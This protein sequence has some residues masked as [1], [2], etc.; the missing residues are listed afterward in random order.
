[1]NYYSTNNRSQKTSFKEA[2]INGLAPDGGLYMPESIPLLPEDFFKGLHKF[3]LHKIAFEAMRAYIHTEVDDDALE[4]IIHETFDFDIPLIRIEENFFSLELFHGPTLSFKDVGARFMARILS[5]LVRKEKKEICVL[6][7]TSGDTGSAVANGF[8]G[9]EGIKVVILYPENGVSEIQ[10][11]QM[12]TLGKNIS[13]IEI[14]GTFDDCQ[15]LVKKAFRDELLA[16]N[17][18]LT[19]ANS[20]NMARLLPQMIYYYYALA[21]TGER[22]PVTFSVPSGN[23]GN[24]TAGLI[25][26]KMGLPANFVAGTN[27]N[28]AFPNYLQSGNFV[29]HPSRK[30]ISNAMDVGNP[31]NFFRILDLYNNSL[32]EI[33]KDISSYIISDDE[34]KKTIKN[35]W[36]EKNYLLDPHGAVA[37]AALM[38]YKQN[39][40]GSTGI[41]LETAHPA[42]FKGTV[43]EVIG[44]KISLPGSLR[45]AMQKEKSTTKLS[46]DF[47][48]LKEFLM[49]NK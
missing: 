40:T 21:Q 23:F 5:H 39:Q 35:V 18:S 41:F 9:A 49:R 1:M 20:I 32:T 8:F 14:K 10:E 4:K 34:T 22:K 45:K 46:A 33:K 28:D 12:T 2:V 24:L 15:A 19:S 25:A 38:K 43:E 48:E 26:K 6:T 3:S 30:T 31:S 16:K 44:E 13:A 29:P 42:K 36:T 37:Y 27:I 17:I 11:K 7:A 47:N